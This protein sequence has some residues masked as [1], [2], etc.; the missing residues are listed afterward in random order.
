MIHS[1]YLNNIEKSDFSWI[2]EIGAILFDIGDTLVDSEEIIKRSARDSAINLKR[3]G[4]LEDIEEFI[5]R[6][7]E[8]DRQCNEI[9]I[10]HLFSSI[11]IIQATVNELDLPRKNAVI[12]SFLTFYREA[13]RQH[14]IFDPKLYELIEYIKKSSGKKVG[15]VS[16][17]TVIEQMEILTRLGIIH[18]L[19]SI[20]ISE[21][22]GYEKPSIELFKKPGKELGLPADAILMI[23]DNYE[24]D[25]IGAKNAGF[26]AILVQK[27]YTSRNFQEKLV[28][29]MII[30]DISSLRLFLELTGKKD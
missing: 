19:D 10:N 11:K 6:F 28:P 5:L 9:H 1:K 27:G 18:L 15:I 24:R 2:D 17:G 29:D 4:L 14:I 30:K 16:D 20:S 7:R 21:E 8:A 25:I 23:G 13:V 22:I 3:I 26:R 12:G